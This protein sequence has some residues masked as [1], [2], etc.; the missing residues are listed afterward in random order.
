MPANVPVNR[1]F[2]RF[3]WAV[4]AYNF[5]VIVWGAFVRASGSGAGCGSHWPD[6]HGEVVPRT[7]SVATMIELTHRA[8]SGLALLAVV[9]QVVWAFRAYPVGDRVRRAAAASM[10]FMLTEAALG[11]GIV[12]LQLVADDASAARAG[13]IGMHLVNTFLLVA[14]LALAAMWASTAERTRLD[15]GDGLGA[16][17]AVFAG[18]LVLTGVAGAITALGDTLF[19]S[20]TLA[21]GLAADTAPGAH[22]LVRLRVIHPVIATATSLLLVLGGAF[23]SMQRPAPRVR[24]AARA[25][26]GLLVVQI[27]MGLLNVLLLAPTWLQLLHLL[28]ADLTWLALVALGANALVTPRAVRAKLR[29]SE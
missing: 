15:A 6:C 28:L 16:G 20:R 29:A 17:L 2:A 27:G 12:L 21:E 19:P 26:S 7:E 14:A 8:T 25:L 4:L 5:A 10:F 9:V 23:V 11:A 22:F 18:A 1:G 13:W 24:A 3:S